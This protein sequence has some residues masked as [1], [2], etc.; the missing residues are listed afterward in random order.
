MPKEKRT[1]EMEVI[2]RQYFAAVYGI[3]E[4]F[5]RITAYL[6][7]RGMEENTLVVL[8]A[9][10]GEMLGD[11]HMSQK[12][13]F[14]EGSA[15]VPLLIMPP[16]RPGL[17]QGKGLPRKL[18]ISRNIRIDRPVT[19]AD[20]YPTILAMAGQDCPE[21]RSG[22]NLLAVS[23]LPEDRVFFGNSLNRNFCVMERKLKLVYSAVGNHALLFDLNRDPQ[24]RHDLSHVPEYAEAF[25]HLWKLLVEH[26][27]SHTPEA[28]T[29]DGAFI[30]YDAPRFPGDMPGRWF[31]FH[32]HDYSVDTFH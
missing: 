13:L 21:G 10:H 27:A 23:D 9:D 12:N 31:G 3:D 2:A 22:R 8:S 32:Y 4:Q 11:H 19:L 25:T 5:G 26:T 15:H 20:I 29:E 17:P 1:P 24:E 16:Q 7:E 14:F 6:R 30:T 18:G 28:L